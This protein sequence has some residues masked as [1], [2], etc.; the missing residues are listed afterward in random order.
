MFARHIAAQ[1]IFN[2][3]FFATVHCNVV[4]NFKVMFTLTVFN[5]AYY[6]VLYSTMISVKFKLS[7]IQ[8]CVYTRVNF[9]ILCA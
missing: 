8:R 7:K 6:I 9:D 5:D 4:G 2:S 1:L 3:V